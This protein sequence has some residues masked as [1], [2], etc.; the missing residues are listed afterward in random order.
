[1][2]YLVD[3]T[4][5]S[6]LRREMEE[7]AIWRRMKQGRGLRGVKRGNCSSDVLSE[8][9]ILKRRESRMWRWWGKIG[10]KQD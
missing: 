1:M 8:R 10:S 7:E 6:H 3:I 2:T 4:G 5:R 9:R